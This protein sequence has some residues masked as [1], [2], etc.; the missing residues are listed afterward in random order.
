V[1][2]VKRDIPLLV[3]NGTE[4]EIEEDSKHNNRQQIQSFEEELRIK[5]QL[6]FEKPVYWSLEGEEKT[7]LFCQRCY[8]IEKKL[9]RL[10]DYGPNWYC[11]ACK[12]GY[13]KKRVGLA[14]QLLEILS[15]L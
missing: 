10:Q 2:L 3:G 4:L 8:D 6:R 9:V 14:F 13:R 7:G 15:S 12:R 5:G 11:V 1:I